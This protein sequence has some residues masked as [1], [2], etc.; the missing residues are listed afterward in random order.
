MAHIL[1]LIRRKGDGYEGTPL[2]EKH[3]CKVLCQFLNENFKEPEKIDELFK[4]DIKH[5]NE[6][7]PE[8]KSLG[9]DTFAT[10]NEAL[11]HSIDFAFGDCVVYEDGV[12]KHWKTPTFFFKDAFIVT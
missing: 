12:W 3:T 7:K 6:G 11:E 10:F 4:G 9:I 1:Y 2:W 8:F 5:L